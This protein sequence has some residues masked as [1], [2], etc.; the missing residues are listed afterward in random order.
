[1]VS[2]VEQ[3]DG[4][5]AELGIQFPAGPAYGK[6]LSVEQFVDPYDNLEIFFGVEPVPFLGLA[7][8][9]YGEFLLPVTEHMGLD[10][11]QLR[12][13]SDSVVTFFWNFRQYHWSVP[14]LEETFTLALSW[15]AYR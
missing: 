2:P 15:S 13:I 11:E 1:M 4:F 3:R 7:G 12:D 6:L 5:A 9:E 10:P 14:L 8:P